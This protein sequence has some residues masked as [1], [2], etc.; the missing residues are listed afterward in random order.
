MSTL[1]LPGLKAW[2]CS[3]LTLHFGKISVLSLSM[4]AALL[5]PALKGGAWRRRTGQQ[6]IRNEF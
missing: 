1:R 3:E 5:N 6:Q 2:A 4:E